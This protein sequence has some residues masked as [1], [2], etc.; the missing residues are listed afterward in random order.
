MADRALKGSAALW[1]IVAVIG[2]WIFLSYIVA[3]YGGAAA[4]GDL[5]AWNKHLSGAYISGEPIGNSAAAA[6]LL[7]AVIILGGGPLQLISPIRN[8]F[9]S[10]HRWVGRTYLTAVVATAVAGLYMLLNRDIGGLPLKLGFILQGVLIFSFAA[11]AL[12]HA[13]ARE[14]DTHRRWALRLFMTASAVWF[15]RIMLMVW[16]A[17]T[18]GVGID[19]STGKGWFIDLMSFGQY[20]PL[21]ILEIYLRTQDHAGASVKFAMA[22]F[23]VAAAGA[24]ALG[25]LMA[26]LGMWFPQG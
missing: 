18:G 2:Q 1:F 21:V 14:I 3:V 8:R 19:F 15:F 24:T 25:V 4:Q 26:T 17:A 9:P 7:L 16:V 12:R 11:M 20:L 5:A 23:L 10:F 13:I 22:A 6:H